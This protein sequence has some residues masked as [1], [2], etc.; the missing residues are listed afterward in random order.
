MVTLATYHVRDVRDFFEHNKWLYVSEAD[1]ETIRDRLRKEIS[2]RKNPLFIELGGDDES[3]EAMRARL[4]SSDPLG[5]RSRAACSATRTARYVWIAAL[6][7]GG[8]FGEHAG[9]ALYHAAEK[10]IRDTTRRATTRRWRPRCWGRWPPR[11][12]A[13][14][15]S[16]ATSSG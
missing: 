9:E 6:P 14:R 5:G 15:R 1:L 10:L 13:A 2:K 16:S 7:P 3:V 4:T 11:S 12:P 8:L